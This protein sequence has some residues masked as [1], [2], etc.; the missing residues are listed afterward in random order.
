MLFRS[1]IW[2]CQ[3]P[4]PAGGGAHAEGPWINRA[5]GTYDFSAKAIVPGSVT[6]PY[7]LDIKLE[8]GQRIISTNSYPSHPTGIYPISRD[9]IA[10]RY[11]RNPNRINSNNAWI[12]LPANPMLAAEPSCA[13][14][15]IGILL[16]GVPLFNALDAPG[17]DAVAHEVQDSCQGHPQITGIY[18]YHNVSTCVDTKREADGH[19]SLVGYLLDGF[20]I[21]GR[22]G[23]GGKLLESKDLDECHGHTHKI[24]WDG[25]PVEMYHYHATWDFPYTAGCLRGR[26]DRALIKQLMGPPPSGFGK[27]SFNKGPPNKGGHPDLAKAAA[28]L[29]ISERDLRDALGPPPPDFDNASRRL[30]ISI[31]RLR[32][33]LE[34]SR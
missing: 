13:P 14:G 34:S 31:D 30:N 4:N 21:Y 2:P 33:A 1:W 9:S 10:Y 23:E 3:A 8:N 7:Q 32:N 26:Y 11:D 18:H 22:H 24:L 6:W 28:L 19:S 29:G 5:Q 17:R 27:G 20:G 12:T 15:A 25:K 16:S